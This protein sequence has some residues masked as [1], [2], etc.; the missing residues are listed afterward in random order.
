MV[1]KRVVHGGAFQSGANFRYPLPGTVLMR[2]YK[3]ETVQVTVLPTGFDYEGEVYPSLSAAA[4]AITGSHTSGFL[5][6]RLTGNGG[7]R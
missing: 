7:R 6:F 4:K 1:T 3:G 2:E 5:F